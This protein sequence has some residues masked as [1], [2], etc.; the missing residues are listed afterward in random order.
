[1]NSSSST[2]ATRNCSNFSSSW[3]CV[4]SRRSTSERH[5][6]MF[7]FSHLYN[8]WYTLPVTTYKS[9]GSEPE[10][11]ALPE[12]VIC[13]CAASG[14]SGATHLFN[15]WSFL[16]TNLHFCP[17]SW[18]QF[19]LHYIVPHTRLLFCPSPLHWVPGGSD[20]LLPSHWWSFGLCLF[21]ELCV[22]EW[23]SGDPAAPPSLTA[24]PLIALCWPL[25]S[26]LHGKI[27]MMEDDQSVI[28]ASHPSVEATPPPEMSF[29]YIG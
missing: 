17:W 15:L 9:A 26:V 12:F 20:P 4:K 29:F 14:A 19:L 2:T 1:M 21:S 10:H 27:P 8:L 6:C 13:L 11:H 16:H 23:C 7:A 18:M 24:P 3:P 22:C 25:S 28:L 5:V